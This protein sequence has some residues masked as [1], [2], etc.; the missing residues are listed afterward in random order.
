[1]KRAAVRFI[2]IWI[3]MVIGGVPP[4]AAIFSALNGLL[5]FHLEDP[6]KSDPYGFMPVRRDLMRLDN[7]FK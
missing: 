7:R 4:W 6:I 1:M 3:F 5:F 2:I